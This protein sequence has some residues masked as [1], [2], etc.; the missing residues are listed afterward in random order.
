MS[1]TASQTLHVLCQRSWDEGR[2]PLDDPAVQDHLLA[3]PE[4]LEAFACIR[5]RVGALADLPHAS[6]RQPR[7]LASW[8]SAA[9][10]LLAAIVWFSTSD[11]NTDAPEHAVTPGFLSADYHQETRRSFTGYIFTREV[12]QSRS[13]EHGM[14]AVLR[15]E[16]SK[17]IHPQLK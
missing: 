14:Y 16:H 7:R 11:T 2:D 4:H 10:L 1:D 6:R 13:S 12:H 9:A 3:H 17:P 5:E 15:I 8:L